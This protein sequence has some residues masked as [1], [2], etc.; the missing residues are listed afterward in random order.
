SEGMIGGLVQT[1]LRIP[2]NAKYVLVFTTTSFPEAPGSVHTAPSTG[3][4]L[5]GS[6]PVVTT[7]SGKTIQLER[8]VTGQL[9][10]EL[11]DISDLK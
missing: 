2:A 7:D 5:I 6:I 3:V 1:F 8:S 11:E 10:L 9:S 4:L